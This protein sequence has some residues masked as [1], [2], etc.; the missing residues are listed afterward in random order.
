M[1]LF[2]RSGGLLCGQERCYNQWSS[3]DF[4][5]FYRRGYSHRKK[6]TPKVDTDLIVKPIKVNN[7]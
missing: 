3:R 6:F 5:F 4:G 7:I 1:A 2:S